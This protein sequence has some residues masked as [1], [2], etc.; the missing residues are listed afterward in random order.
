[1]FVFDNIHGHIEICDRAKSIIDTQEF[2]R[3]RDIKQLGCIYQV[4][5]GA[6][7]NR[8][9]HSI[10]VYYLAKK[11]MNILNLKS[12]KD[13]DKYFTDEEYFLISIS[14]LIH[15]LGHGPLSHLFDDYINFSIHEDRSVKIFRHINKKYNL[16][17]NEADIQFISDCIYPK[18]SNYKKYTR[19]KFC[20]QIVSNFNGIDVDRFDYIMRDCKMT[21]LNYGIEYERIMENTYIKDLELV[22]D[23]KCQVAIDSFYNTRYILYKEICNHHTVISIEQHIKEILKEIDDTFKIS[24]SVRNED[25]DNFCKI[26]DN[27]LSI[28]GFTE[29]L[30]KAKEI[31]EDIKCRN[32]YKLVGEIVSDKKIDIVSFNKNIVV[33][34]TKIKYYSDEMPIYIKDKKFKSLKLED[35]LHKDEYIT[36]IMCKNKEDIIAQELFESI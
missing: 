2:Q 25:W 10:G 16:K 6:S 17:Y 24:E 5:T 4:F 20:F 13:N 31:L 35:I 23:R 33:I 27:I 26:T 30:E 14:A 18:N 11:Y 34:K 19:K 21:G 7:H 3:L 8:F 22:Y 12:D 15:D 9:E 29:N 32:I 28:I 36:K 1:M